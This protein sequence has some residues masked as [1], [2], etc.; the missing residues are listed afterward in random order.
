[1]IVFVFLTV[2]FLTMDV[3]MTGTVAAL[4]IVVLVIIKWILKPIMRK[5]GEENQDFYS[6]LYKWIDQ[7]VM[8]I[9]EIKVANKESY[10]I[11]RKYPHSD[12]TR[13]A[14]A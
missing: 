8:G 3:V 6:G 13:T 2:Y 9:K 7:S 4:L 5:A 14:F 11:S 12:N 1:M 10:F